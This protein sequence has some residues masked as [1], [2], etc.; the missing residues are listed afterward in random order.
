MGETVRGTFPG[1]R[2]RSANSIFFTFV[3]LQQTEQGALQ[4]RNLRYPVNRGTRA[5]TAQGHLIDFVKTDRAGTAGQ[6]ECG[7]NHQKD[8]CS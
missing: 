4:G 7:K 3:C 6:A 5:V 2:L 8:E 1:F